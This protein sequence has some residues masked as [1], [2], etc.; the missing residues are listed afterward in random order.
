MFRVVRRIKECRLALIEW[1]K[2]VKANTKVKIQEIK[3]KLK[4]AREE[5]DPCN[6]GD[7]ASLKR[8]LSKAY[9]DEELFWSQKSRSRWLK[10]G[11]KNTTFFHI[12]VTTKRKRN[13]IS[14]LQKLNRDWCRSDQEIEEELCQHYRELFISTDPKEFDEML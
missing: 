12:S 10:E 11:D 14:M 6:S 1:N 9:K 3:E 7:I 13:R 5:G 2:R 4:V 8:Q